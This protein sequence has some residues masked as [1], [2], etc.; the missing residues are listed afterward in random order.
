MVSNEI[1]DFHHDRFSWN[2]IF[3]VKTQYLVI[4]MIVMDCKH[5]Q[6]TE[7]YCFLFSKFERKQQVIF[8]T[9]PHWHL[10][11]SEPTYSPYWQ[12]LVKKGKRIHFGT[13]FSFIFQTTKATI[14][15][16]LS[17]YSMDLNEYKSHTIQGTSVCRVCMFA[18]TSCWVTRKLTSRCGF[19][20][21][22]HKWFKPKN[23]SR[24]KWCWS[25]LQSTIFFFFF[26]EFP[27][28]WA[29]LEEKHWSI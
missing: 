17:F 22:K 23:C 3:L 21:L 26:W 27:E 6:K 13:R 16:N 28:K 11:L 25:E 5:Q 24:G 14:S 1:R 8:F 12:D 7:L 20:K 19:I 15:V 18:W 2:N 10:C 9:G 4:I 29:G